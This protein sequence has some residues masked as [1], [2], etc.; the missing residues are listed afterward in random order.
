MAGWLNS[1]V[2]DGLD[3]WAA[4]WDACVAGWVAG[5]EGWVYAGPAGPA[6][7]CS[8]QHSGCMSI[9]QFEAGPMR[10]T[11]ATTAL[12]CCR[13]GQSPRPSPVPVPSSSPPPPSAVLASPP[14]PPPLF[15]CA[16]Q[17][18]ANC[19]GDAST[20]RMCMLGFGRDAASGSC[21]PC[22]DER[23]ASC[24][25]DARKCWA[26]VK[27]YGVY[28]EDPGSCAPCQIEGC[29]ACAS[30][31]DR[32]WGCAPEYTLVGGTCVP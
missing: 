26:C 15:P 31:A 23:C 32:C 12:P 21:Q 11:A 28:A 4:R 13:P 27:G 24:A 2:A 20:C 17:N 19:T 18:C 16:D 8:Q 10:P 9:R 30:D 5:W 6:M 29:T 3:A 22:L 25:S 1:W 7:Q 14:P